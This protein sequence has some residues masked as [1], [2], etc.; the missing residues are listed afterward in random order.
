MGKKRKKTKKPK[1]KIGPGLIVDGELHE[2]DFGNDE[3]AIGF[4]LPN[5]SYAFIDEEEDGSYVITREDGSGDWI[6]RR[7]EDYDVT[8]LEVAA[9]YENAK[10]PLRL[11]LAGIPLEGNN[12]TVVDRGLQIRN[13]IGHMEVPLLYSGNSD[14]NRFQI[15]SRQFDRLASRVGPRFVD[16]SR[17]FE[18]R[19]GEISDLPAVRQIIEREVTE[20]EVREGLLR[21]AQQYLDETPGFFNYLGQFEDGLTCLVYLCSPSPYSPVTGRVLRGTVFNKQLIDTTLGD[22]NKAMLGLF[23]RGIENC[24]REEGVDNF[25]V[26]S[27]D[28]SYN[29]ILPFLRE[30]GYKREDHP[31]RVGSRVKIYRYEVKKL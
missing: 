2:I 11:A 26:A 25:L 18:F 3:Y 16:F 4:P 30:K 29:P 27:G 1:F 13:A 19:R 31:V 12:L 22:S 20:S 7:I 10:D 24:L 9:I 8:C 17:N 15:K 14:L 5:G 6:A 23:Y 21:N 28:G